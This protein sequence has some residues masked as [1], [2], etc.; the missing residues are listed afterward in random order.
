M[1]TIANITLTDSVAA[2]TVFTPAYTAPFAGWVSRTSITSIGSPT[3]TASLTEATN[4]RG[5]NRVLVKHNMPIE[6]TDSSTGI[7]T[8]D[9]VMRASHQYILPAKATLLQ[10]QNFGAK[11][12]DLLSETAI[13]S[14]Y[15]NLEAAF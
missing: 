13:R 6:V 11:D 1:T 12:R 15:E 8:V 5:T 14:Y 3:I 4:E 7:T 2:N 10:R 9:D